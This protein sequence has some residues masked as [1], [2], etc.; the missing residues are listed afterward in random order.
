M[1]YNTPSIDPADLGSLTGAF[2]FIVNKILQGV[3]GRLPAQ[4]IAFDRNANRV[5]VQPLIKVIT[6]D[7]TEVSRA[8]I[9]S[10]PV[11]QIGGGGVVLNFNLNP[12][13]L[14]WIEANDRDISLFLQSYAESK[15]NTNRKFSFS[16]GVFVPNIMHNFTIN[17]EDDENCVLQN[18][19]G[20]VRIAIWSDKIKITAPSGLKVSGGIV[21]DNNGMNITGDVHVSGN[22]TASGDITPHIPP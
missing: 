22:I 8:Q 3:S 10:V 15:P 5:R 20:T 2:R 1:T 19:S 6:T 13:D 4:V 16:D 9:A 11:C 21:V 17:S 7:G 14:G 18:L 12:G